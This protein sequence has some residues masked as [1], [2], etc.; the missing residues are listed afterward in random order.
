MASTRR[1]RQREATAAEIKTVASRQMVENGPAALSLRGIAA[2]IGM[3]APGIYRYFPSR[4]GL[5]TALIVDAY[6]ALGE[7]IDAAQR[8]VPEADYAGRFRAAAGAYRGWSLDRPADFALIFGTPIPNYHA[9]AEITSPVA[10]RAFQP[11]VQIPQEAWVAG[12]L[13]SELD[14][15][16]PSDETDARLAAWLADEGLT[17]PAR[18]LRATLEGWGLM[19]GMVTLELIGQLPPVVGD[20][21]EFYET[22]IRSF[23]RRFGLRDADGPSRARAP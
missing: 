7:A 21:T 11:F 8:A 3:T 13:E 6:R 22:A 18:M 10:R 2:E 1:E 5:V 15:S 16:G 14:E 12:C 9:P 4:D 20:P 23:V 17:L 19:H